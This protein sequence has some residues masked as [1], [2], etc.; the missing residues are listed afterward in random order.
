MIVSIINCQNLT[1][2][3]KKKT[4]N[5]RLLGRMKLKLAFESRE[6]RLLDLAK[7]MSKERN[8]K[9]VIHPARVCR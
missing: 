4:F 3:K 5:Q 7:T 9:L 6:K 2:D 1:D 8:T